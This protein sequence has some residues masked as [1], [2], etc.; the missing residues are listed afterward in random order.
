MRELLTTIADMLFGALRAPRP[1]LSSLDRAIAAAG[2]A[3][4]TARRALAIAVA[5]D[6]RET[7]RRDG[8]I[9][10]VDDLESRAVEAIRAGRDDLAQSAAET[11]AA[12]RTEIAASADASARFQGEMALARREVD[13]QRRRLA[14][15][16]RGRRLARVGSALNSTAMTAG[17]LDRLSEAEA[18]L[19]Q[20][21]ADNGD[22]QA[23]REAM[24]PAVDRQIDQLS[25][26]GFGAPL[27][28]RT[29]DVMARLRAMAAMPMITASSQAASF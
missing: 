16:D 15:L 27:A 7:S 5:E 13:A 4:T 12:I 3:H 11:V 8:L 1:T 10:K 14:D 24:S 6:A 18:T 22:A 9:A 26:E 20:I 25:R 23:I 17:G 2:A 29:E 19:A 21:Y 28:V